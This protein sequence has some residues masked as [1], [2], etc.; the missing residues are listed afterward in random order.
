M[1]REPKCRRVTSLPK[2]AVF[3][4]V[5]V[6]LSKLEETVV[7][8]E[9]LEALRLKDLLGWEQAECAVSMRVSRPT[10]Q[11]ILNEGRRKMA[12]ALTEGKAIRIEG[13]DYCI[14]Q[15]HCRKAQKLIKHSNNCL[16]PENVANG[17]NESEG[18]PIIA[19]SKIAICANVDTPLAVVDGRFGRCAYF[20]L[21]DEAQR[22]LA[23]LVNNGLGLKQGAGTGAVQELLRRGVGILIC[24][25][26]GPNALTVFQKAGGMVY[27][28]EEGTPIDMVIDSYEAG[29]LMLINI[30]NPQ[31]GE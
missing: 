19:W 14:G 10:F 1:A 2:Y 20:L 6:S 8:I 9:E 16:Y 23:A 27:A 24:N 25:R 12:E 17:E 3:R 11:R 29:E 18:S 7:K 15:E 28:A 5:G 31:A 22:K 4:P 13:G 26:I 21:W 30:P